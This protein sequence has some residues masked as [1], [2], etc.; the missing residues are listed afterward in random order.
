[1]RGRRMGLPRSW[2]AAL[3]VV[4]A[5]RA[6]EKLDSNQVDQ[7]KLALSDLPCRETEGK[8]TCGPPGAVSLSW[9]VVW[10]ERPTS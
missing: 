1:M 9:C 2:L 4:G 3:A 5:A 10:G 7:R 6:I 8:H